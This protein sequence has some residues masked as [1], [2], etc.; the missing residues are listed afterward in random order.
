MN[1]SMLQWQN[2]TILLGGLST[3]AVFSF[4]VKENAL[5]RFFEHFY[6][7]IATGL[8][9]I[10]GFKNF[11]WPI[12][13]VPLFGLDIVQYP[14][15]T[16]SKEYNPWVLL[17][18]VA[19]VFGLFYYF[20]YT[21][22]YAWLSK[23]AIGFSLGIGGGIAFKAFFSEWVPQIQSSFKPLLVRTCKEGACRID[24]W[25][26]F[27]NAV[28]IFTFVAVMYYFFFSFKRKT[29]VGAGMAHGGRLMLMVCFGAFFG[30]T[31][32]ARMALLVERVSFLLIDW[33]IV[34]VNLL[35]FGS[36]GG[37]S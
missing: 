1:L 36:G 20:A 31:V 3:I 11:L 33:R 24:L 21:R 25:S 7:G 37:Q 12:I 26:S 6:I 27:E 8:G 28:F 29:R 34:I 16:F 18:G 32:M 22:R 15:G 19:V 9:V 5:Y 30:S 14:D 2:L 23:L 17:Y 10:L 4:L 13:L 35:G